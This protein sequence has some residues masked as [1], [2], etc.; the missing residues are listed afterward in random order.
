MRLD[1]ATK[2][3]D[4]YSAAEK[5]LAAWGRHPVT[6]ITVIYEVSRTILSFTLIFGICI[7]FL[8][9]S[10]VPSAI[11]S[12]LGYGRSRQRVTAAQGTLLGQGIS[13]GTAVS[14]GGQTAQ[15]LIPNQ[16]GV[17]RQR[18]SVNTALATGTGTGRG[19]GFS[20]GSASVFPSNAPTAPL[21]RCVEGE[22]RNTNGLCVIPEV[23]RSVFVY[24]PPA[25]LQ[26]SPG[27]PP[28]I[29]LPRIER[30]VVFVR[31]PEGGGA[32]EPIVI[33]PPAQNNVI[34]VLNKQ[35]GGVQAPRV[36]EVPAPPS[37]SPEVIFVNYEDGENPIL[38]GGFD[39][40]TALNAAIASDGQVINGAV[41]GGGFGGSSGGVTGGLSGSSGGFVGSSGF[42]VSSGSLGGSGGFGGGSL[43]GSG[44]FGGSGR[45]TSSSGPGTSSG[46]GGIGGLGGFTLTA[47]GEIPDSYASYASSSNTIEVELT[48]DVGTGNAGDISSLA[49]SNTGTGFVENESGKSGVLL[50]SRM[51]PV[52]TD[53][54][55]SL[56]SLTGATI[57]LS[58]SYNTP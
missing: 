54:G 56:E 25:Q 21:P 12:S 33:P 42:G 30:N 11:P 1:G 47:N 17:T 40:Q 7:V 29:P 49:D 57:A 44:G 23:T 19:Q 6:D 10:L 5:A 41:G 18:A 20:S 38:P 39:L 3:T 46:L 36:I 15:R 50:V 43:G 34:Y 24:E 16:V 37:T 45:L 48:N 13:S 35:T 4:C 14:T 2:A 9:S 27:P 22:V 31:L 51:T 26:L 28:D 58:S 8:L 55:D 32:P 52:I 53:A